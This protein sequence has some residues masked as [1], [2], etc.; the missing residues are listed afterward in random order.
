[1]DEDAAAEPVEVEAVAVDQEG[2]RGS[3]FATAPPMDTTGL[4]PQKIFGKGV[5]SS[6]EAAEELST[7]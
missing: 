7:N 5:S 2:G 6:Q 3:D 1:M 4:G